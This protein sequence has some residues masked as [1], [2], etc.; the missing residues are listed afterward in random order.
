MR[1]LQAVIEQDRELLSIPTFLSHTFENLL[2]A[3][4]GEGP[5]TTHFVCKQMAGVGGEGS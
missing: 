4:G 3:L 1:K 5:E 2:I